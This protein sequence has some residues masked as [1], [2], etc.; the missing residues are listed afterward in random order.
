M[1]QI[2]K[3]HV[4]K[5]SVNDSV[6]AGL[7]NVRYLVI[8]RK[9]NLG[10]TQTGASLDFAGTR[11]GLASWLAAPGPMGTLDF[12]SPDASFAGSVLI[13]NPGSFCEQLLP[14]AGASERAL[15]EAVTASVGGEMTI[16]VD[17][18]L[19]PTPSWKVAIE[20]N[21]PARLQA[22]I[23]QAARQGEIQITQESV[24]G[25]TYYKAI[26]PKI[27][28]EVDYVYIDGYLLAAPS[29]ALLTSAIQTR[30]N[31]STLARSAAFRAQL[32]QD[33]HSNFSA[34]LYY[35]M[36]VQ[37]GP[38]VD[39]LKTL[40]TPEQQKS[41]AMLVANREPGMIY[42]YGEPDRIVVASRSGFFGMG[43][44]TLVRL[45]AKGGGAFGQLLPPV[46]RLDSRLNGSRN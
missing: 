26:P 28:Y 36:G 14:A 17:G 35:N 34:I 41:A 29:E 33:G 3:S 42:A 12:V 31:G 21:D 32:P 1:E 30:A 4:P 5:S 39:Q 10:R 24:N 2:L 45:N 8:E 43:L 6:N 46:F 23:E 11:H 38:A 40:M 44:D 20:V 16:A 25:R 7:D 37:A 13:R 18:P 27:A 15:V 22:A 9:D 19:L